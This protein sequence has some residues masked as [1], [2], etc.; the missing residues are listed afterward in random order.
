ML[1]T[2]KGSVFLEYQLALY[3]ENFRRWASIVDEDIRS[4]S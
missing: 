3:D 4:S 2:S 1:Q